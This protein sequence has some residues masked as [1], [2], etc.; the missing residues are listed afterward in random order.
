MNV[1]LEML[2]VRLGADL[3]DAVRGVFPDLAPTLSELRLIE[4]LVEVAKP[5]FRL[6]S[7]LLRY[8][9]QDG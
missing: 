9:L 5:M 6:L 3:I 8:P 7:G 2:L 1:L 4:Q